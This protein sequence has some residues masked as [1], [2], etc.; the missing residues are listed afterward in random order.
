L[1]ELPG[2]VLVNGDAGV[3]DE[4]VDRSELGFGQLDHVLDRHAVGD[5]ALDRNPVGLLRRLPDLG[6][7]SRRD[8]DT[9]ARGCELERDVP[10]DSPSAAR[11]EGNLALKVRVH[12]PILWRLATLNP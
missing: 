5:V 9:G 11:D 6:T 1:T 8:G 2:G 10:S 12:S 3:G 7:A 4:Q